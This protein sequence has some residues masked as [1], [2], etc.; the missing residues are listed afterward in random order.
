[1]VEYSGMYTH[2]RDEH[3]DEFL[4]A[5][6]TGFLVRKIATNSFPSVE[7]KVNGDSWSI[8]TKTL[9]KTWSWTFKIGQEI[10]L[11]FFPYSDVK[12]V[13][14]LDGNNLL[15]TNPDDPDVITERVFTDD[16]MEQ[17][18]T[19]KPSNTVC[20]RYFKREKV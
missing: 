18:M 4:K 14:T 13:F 19:H 16:G 5:I 15:Q 7:I 8:E 9:P 10:M 11:E 2:L 6:G 3:F 12:A 1:M 17:K 20:R